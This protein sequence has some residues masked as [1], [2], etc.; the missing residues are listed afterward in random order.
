MRAPA[1]RNHWRAILG[2]LR[3][4]A[5]PGEEQRL[6]EALSAPG[7][8]AVLGFVNAHAMNLMADDIEFYRA[9]SAAD[10]LL[11]DGSGMAILFRRAG[12][13]PG[14][15]MNGTDLIPKLLAAFAGRR[16]ALWGTEE[17]YLGKAAQQ[18][19]ALYGVQVVS[20][21]HGFAEA[22]TYLALARQTQPEL[23]LLGMGMPRQEAIAARLAAS[24]QPC[25][26]VCGGAILDFLGGKVSRAPGWLRRLGC[27]WLFRLL[28]EPRRLFA[29]YVLGNPLF[30]LRTLACGR[31][32]AKDG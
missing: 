11:R 12:L 26:I 24:G 2:K 19:Q 1:W 7:A 8:S 25:L 30:L 3:V 4:V 27:E 32:A 18:C 5:S 20:V 17:P 28:R 14:L 6:L 13:E 31:A 15:N 23:V 9:L 29:R 21:Q 10:V 16:V 22:G